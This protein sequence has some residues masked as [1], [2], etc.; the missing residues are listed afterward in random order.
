MDTKTKASSSNP[1]QLNNNKYHNLQFYL[2]KLFN[3]FIEA[4]CV[5]DHQGL[6]IYSNKTYSNIFNDAEPINFI[7]NF[8]FES[9]K[10]ILQFLNNSFTENIP[11]HSIEKELELKNGELL[12][13][14]LLPSFFFNDKNQKLLLLILRDITSK[15]RCELQLLK[16]E[17]QYRS[18]F[19]QTNDAI[20]ICYLNYG[21]SLSNFIEIN[22]TA[23]RVLEYTKEELIEQ[24]PYSVIFNK[25][26]GE[27]VKIIDI[28]LSEGHAIFDAVQLTKSGK[29]IP[30]EVNSHLIIYNDKPAV[31]FV[32]R[33]VT[34]REEA[35]RKIRESGE[36]LRN[37][38]LHLQNIRE[39]ER[40]LI[41]REIHDELGQMLTFLK[42]QITLIGKKLNENQ[43]LLKEKV[44]SSLK[45]IDDSIN[46]IQRIA[47][48]LRPNVLDE[49]GI[50][51][52][53]DWQAKEF[54]EHT[55]IICTCECSVGE[56]SLDKEKSTALFRI[57]QEALTNVARH[58]N[59]NKVL[60]N[61]N[62]YKNQLILEIKDNGKGI[63]QNQVNNPKSLGILGMKE[64]AMLLGGTVNIKS[65]MNSGTTVRVE[66]P[67]INKNVTNLY[68]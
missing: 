26:E 1:V 39:E 38:A 62:T 6:I 12:W 68:D 36:R 67:I 55:G 32:L 41:A 42:I 49:L 59:A 46:S 50:E 64:R 56:F 23:C 29:Y 53:I 3:E 18:I 28:I 48:K 17:D 11:T 57:F 58:A 2:S 51:A 60:V 15:K 13:L 27:F 19:N 30:A 7:S 54:S 52:A 61:L 43:H 44:D 4:V 8:S 37:L 24:N 65:S 16:S 9:Q 25:Y 5:L 10:Q 21:N 14:E 66:L 45:M 35:E 63:T 22:E 47:E 40:T 31:L 33:D 34:Q 20:C